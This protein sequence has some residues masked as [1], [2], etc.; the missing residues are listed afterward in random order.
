MARAYLIIEPVRHDQPCATIALDGSDRGV[1][2]ALVWFTKEPADRDRE[3]D[4]FYKGSFAKFLGG[5]ICL[6][7]ESADFP[8]IGEFAGQSDRCTDI[9]CQIATHIKLA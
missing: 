3:V 5:D 4:A 6:G 2:G 8:A 7:E 9:A 1:D